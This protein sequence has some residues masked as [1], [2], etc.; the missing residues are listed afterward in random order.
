MEREPPPQY[1]GRRTLMTTTILKVPHN[2]N[3]S[4]NDGHPLNRGIISFLFFCLLAFNND[5][6]DDDG[7]HHDCHHCTTHGNGQPP[8]PSP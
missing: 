7:H 4:H 8:R 3:A 6:D 1:Q 5:D 2:S